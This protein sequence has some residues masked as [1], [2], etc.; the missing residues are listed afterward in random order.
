MMTDTLARLFAQRVAHLTM[1]ERGRLI[2]AYDCYLRGH[3]AEGFEV[4]GMSV[5]GQA[6]K[7]L[8]N[9]IN[10]MVAKGE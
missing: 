4:L 1:D 9:V 3:I 6:A 7:D 5:Q 8:L 2:A 10:V